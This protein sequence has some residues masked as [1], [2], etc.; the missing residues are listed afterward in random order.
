[1][2]P[3]QGKLIFDDQCEFCL[4]S[5]RLLR[6]LDWFS[7]IEFI[8]L[9]KAGQ[10][11]TRYSITSKAMQA[12]IHYISPSGYV[13]AGAKAFRA[14]GKKIPLLFPSAVMLHLPFALKLAS[15]IYM[16]IAVNRYALSR[17]M[18]CSSKNCSVH[19]DS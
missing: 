5:I 7:T 11:M 8:P 6:Q 1:M 2:H 4:R 14:F 3:S 18:K 17:L 13:T 15:F 9:G 12:E 10:I 16:K 19:R